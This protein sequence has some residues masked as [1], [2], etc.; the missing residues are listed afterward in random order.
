[1]LEDEDVSM[2]FYD[3]E[4]IELVDEDLAIAIAAKLVTRIFGKEELALQEPLKA[5]KKDNDWVVLGS[6]IPS[7]ADPD[8]LSEGHVELILNRRNGKIFRFVRY[9]F[10]SPVESEG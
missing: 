10:F 8:V 7:Y 9:K 5:E 3:Y 2:M 4:G 6:R 1:M